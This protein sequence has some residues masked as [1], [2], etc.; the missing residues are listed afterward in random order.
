MKKEKDED[1]D[2]LFK[3]GL[4]NP[5]GEPVYREADWEAMEQLLEQGKKRPA[6]I[7]LLPWLGTAAAIVL[8]VLGWLFF[9]PKTE[10]D[11]NK[12]GQ[13]QLTVA[14][15][16]KKDTGT[17]GGA[18]RHESADSSKQKILTPANYA[19][20]PVHHGGQKNANRSLPYLPVGP[21][22]S[23]PVKGAAKDQ[24]NTALAS[25]K[26][27]EAQ[28]K[29]A[30]GSVDAAGNPTVINAVAANASSK[31]ADK[32]KKELGT[33]DGQNNQA[34]T[35]NLAA[36]TTA[37]TT[38]SK[39]DETPAQ[40]RPD[41]A[42]DKSVAKSK[43]K[44]RYPGANRAIFAVS[45]IATTDMNGVNS[46]QGA[47][48]GGNIGGLFSVNVNKW[49]FTTGVM[50]SIKPYKENFADYH[51]NYP[52]QTN[53]L[54][55]GVNCRM[56][57]IP[58]NV[59]Y[60]VYKNRGNKITVGSGLSS[61][62][63]L[64]EDYKFNYAGAY[65]YGPAGYSVINKNRNILGVLNLDATYDHQINSKFGISFQ[66]YLKLPLSNVGASQAK[67]QSAGVAVGLSWNL[68]SFKKP[69]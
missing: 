6:I 36:N 45:A 3:T 19:T 21:A 15:P 9:R 56:L 48:V 33:V 29:Q 66:P 68:N 50:Y 49:T 4:E 42:T 67:L 20:N 38:N 16:S 58:L 47:R 55:V 37:A 53:P 10:T 61:Y 13:P 2:K 23:L 44:L 7:F 65:A 18:I 28:D 34:E 5:A 41:D 11:N 32:D 57:D 46:L 60:Q 69:D 39:K 12:K 8:V 54:S 62:I 26:K 17:S 14:G 27:E 43:S 22:A 25:N 59:N 1:L 64:R 35:N 30:P 51:T 40:A 24:N 63:I 52:F 31:T